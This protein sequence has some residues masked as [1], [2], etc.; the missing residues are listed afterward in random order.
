V[1]LLTPLHIQGSSQSILVD[2]G[3]VPEGDFKS[4]QLRQYDETGVITVLGILRQSQDKPDFGWRH[5]DIPAPGGHLELWNFTNV[6]GIARQI[7]YPLLPVFIQQAPAPDWNQIPIRSQPTLDL[8]EGPHL[9]YALQWFAFALILG[10]GYP[11]FIR[12]QENPV[13]VRK[14]S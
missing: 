3:W 2:R 8:S 10:G 5:D 12:R 6:S 14:N 11:F 13:R 9:G 4:H 1:H 7:P